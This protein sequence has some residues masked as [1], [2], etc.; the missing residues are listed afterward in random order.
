MVKR[1][2]NFKQMFLADDT[3]I[4]GIDSKIHSFNN[5]TNN[6]GYIPYQNQS[7][8]ECNNLKDSEKLP[9]PEAIRDSNGN[10]NT[11]IN[12]ESTSHSESSSDDDGDNGGNN[13]NGERF[14]PSSYEENNDTNDSSLNQRNTQPQSNGE[15]SYNSLNQRII[16]P[17]QN[18]SPSSSSNE[19]DSENPNRILNFQN[20]NSRHEYSPQIS[21]IDN[22][23]PHPNINQDNSNAQIVNSSQTEMDITNNRDRI[24]QQNEDLAGGEEQF[25]A[26][27]HDEQFKDINNQNISQSRRSANKMKRLKSKI[28]MKKDDAQRKLKKVLSPIKES[29]A[30]KMH[31]EKALDKD[32]E[33]LSDIE[34]Q[35]ENIEDV[36][37]KRNKNDISNLSRIRNQ[38]KRKEKMKLLK[39]K[40]Q[41]QRKLEKVLNPIKESR[42]SKMHDEKALDEDEEMLSDIEEQHENIED[43][44]KKRNKNDISNLSRIRKQ[45]KRKEKMKL[46]KLKQQRL[47]QLY[48]ENKNRKIERHQPDGEIETFI[49]NKSNVVKDDENQT[50]D[51]SK[52]PTIQLRKFAY[53]TMPEQENISKPEIRVAKFADQKHFKDEENISNNLEYL[54][55]LCMMKFPKYSSLK[56]H[57]LE[58]HEKEQYKIEFPDK[59]KY[60]ALGRKVKHNNDGNKFFYENFNMNNEDAT[61]LTSYWCSKCQKFFKSFRSMQRHIHKHENGEA[62]AKRS[63]TKDRPIRKNK[64]IFYEAY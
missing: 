16:Q 63:I 60:L 25:T 32:E 26:P 40:Q 47:K 17:L 22:I 37:K 61:D 35:H 33:M 53:G 62:T 8:V 56:Q 39:L 3:L 49:D 43:V 41:R 5:N 31:D 18:Y 24:S 28:R 54:C 48:F 51:N 9:F 19:S 52:R 36:R 27:L 46:L 13:P 23:L 15:I 45:Q 12:D 14:P 7:C 58:N 1:N 42:A 20:F 38:Q 57:L 10:I 44:R 21:P 50:E 55:E 4:N 64:K 30:S 11:T 29:R 34:E 2:T 59:G 6:L